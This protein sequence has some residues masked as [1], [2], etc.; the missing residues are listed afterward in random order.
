MFE[1]Y[2][3]Y[4]TLHKAY[5]ETLIGHV[6]FLFLLCERRR[7]WIWFMFVKSY[8]CACKKRASRGNQRLLV[9][10]F[11]H[12]NQRKFAYIEV[13]VPNTWR[14]LYFSRKPC[15]IGHLSKPAFSQNKKPHYSLLL[16]L[17]SRSLCLA[18]SHIILCYENNLAFKGQ[19]EITLLSFFQLFL[20]IANS[21]WFCF[22]LCCSFH[23]PFSL[24]K[25]I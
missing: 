16:Q 7:N 17:L 6:E 11:H 13:R 19:A 24:Y 2:F 21:H 25:C 18:L 22:H 23:K 10:C 3:L 9:D 15:L 12:P 8:I 4:C 1:R 14:Y 20:Y 5:F